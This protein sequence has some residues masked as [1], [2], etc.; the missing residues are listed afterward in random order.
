MTLFAIAKF[1]FKNTCSL[2]TDIDCR[3]NEHVSVAFTV[4]VLLL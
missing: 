3:N 2:R 1:Y 4:T